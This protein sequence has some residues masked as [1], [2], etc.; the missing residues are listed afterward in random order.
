MS[1]FASENKK[2]LQKIKGENIPNLELKNSY[3][4]TEKLVLDF[5]KLQ[6]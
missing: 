1:S 3:Y 5:T 2:Y 4:S 6:K